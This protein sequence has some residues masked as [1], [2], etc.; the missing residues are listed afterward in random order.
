MRPNPAIGSGAPWLVG[1]YG[2]RVYLGLYL[3]SESPKPL[4][5]IR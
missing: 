4:G 2:R 3:S 5:E 1:E